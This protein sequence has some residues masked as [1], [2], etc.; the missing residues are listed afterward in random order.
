MVAVGVAV[1]A[2][3]DVVALPAMHTITLKQ[4]TFSMIVSSIVHLITAKD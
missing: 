3:W 2:F 4:S 1:A